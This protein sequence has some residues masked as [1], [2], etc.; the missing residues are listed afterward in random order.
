MLA[1]C[2]SSSP[3]SSAAPSDDGGAIDTGAGDTGSDSGI[4]NP[5]PA[6]DDQWTWVD[7]PE[8][9]CASGTPTGI[10]V[11]PHAGATNLMFYF[12]GGGGCTDA[13]TCWGPTPG[14]RNLDGYDSTTFATAEQRGYP[15]LDRTH[16]GNPMSAM[17]MVYIPY[18]T[19]DLHGG[20][21]EVD[22]Q[23]SGTTKPTY[24]WGAKDLDIFLER[25]APTFAQ[26]THVWSMG[27]SAGGFG[28]FLDFDRISRAFPGVR[29]DIIDDS[30]PPIPPKGGSNNATA[31]A[32]WG[33]VPPAGCTG[34]NSLESIFAFDRKSQPASSFGFLSFTQDTTISRFFGYTV[35]EFPAVIDSFSS[36]LAG[37]PH[38]ATYLVTNESSHVVESDPTLAPQY[39]PWLTQMV[40]DD[41]AW[42]NGGYAHP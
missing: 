24:F 42:K 34:C 26:T 18:C 4:A 41:S 9:K 25:I 1:A 40:N 23:V 35:A 16:A 5:I 15:I 27:T 3:G 31:F 10:A 32:A 2:S 20:S 37:D 8:S 39:F 7:F 14:A 11:N 38:A 36:S 12:E 30:G 29:V 6:A 19:G 22:L 17:N 28:A 13:S 33:L 21:A